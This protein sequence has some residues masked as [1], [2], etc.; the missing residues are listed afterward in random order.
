[1]ITTYIAHG[2]GGALPSQPDQP[3]DA[4]AAGLGD[5]GAT[6]SGPLATPTA[7]APVHARRCDLFEARDW[8]PSAKGCALNLQDHAWEVT[9]VM[10]PEPP[11][12]HSKVVDRY[13]DKS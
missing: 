6:A 10:K 9:Y 1:M 5:P 3:G 4:G 7:L 2:S 8:I 13:D 11:R 12:S